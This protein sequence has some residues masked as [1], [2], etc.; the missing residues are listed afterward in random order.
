V[1]LGVCNLPSA[2]AQEVLLNSF[3]LFSSTVGRKLA[4]G[5]V[6]SIQSRP[7]MYSLMTSL[8]VLAAGTLHIR[9]GRIKESRL[10]AVQEASLEPVLPATEDV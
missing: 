5:T 10:A 1:S 3:P 8:L 4:R 6:R 9:K 7:G 2:A